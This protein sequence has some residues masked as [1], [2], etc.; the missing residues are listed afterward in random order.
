MNKRTGIVKKHQHS[1]KNTIISSYDK[2]IYYLGEAVNSG[3]THDYRLFK[4]E[5]SKEL[6]LFFTKN[7]YD[8]LGYLGIQKEYKFLSLKIPFKKPQKSKKILIQA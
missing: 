6:N 3:K 8:D 1:L 4:N 5:F 2:R 7:V